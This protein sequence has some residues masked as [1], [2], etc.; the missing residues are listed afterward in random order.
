MLRHNLAATWMVR[1]AA[2]EQAIQFLLTQ[3]VTGWLLGHIIMEAQHL[4]LV[5]CG[6]MSR[7][8]AD[9]HSLA[10]TLMVM[11]GATVRAI[12]FLLTQL[13]TG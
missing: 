5:M 13:V 2:I 7:A 8:A 9:G 6:F 10:A 11:G 3:M 4:M 1:G 12:Q